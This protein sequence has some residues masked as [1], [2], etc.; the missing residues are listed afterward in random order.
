MA[1]PFTSAQFIAIFPEF[2]A[3]PT[4]DV[5]VPLV[6]EF[7]SSDVDPGKFGADY[8]RALMLMTAHFLTISARRGKGAITSTR[9]GD[10]STSYS[11][12]EIKRELDATEYGRLFLRLARRKVG[13]PQFVGESYPRHLGRP[14]PMGF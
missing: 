11:P 6:L 14:S 3:L 12:G 10:L 7:L 4:P 8:V 1:D 5:T 9:V 2:G 13:G